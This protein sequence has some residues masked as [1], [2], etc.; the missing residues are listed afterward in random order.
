MLKKTNSGNTPVTDPRI[1]I[2]IDCLGG[3]NCPRAQVGGISLFFRKHPSS[4]IRFLLFGEKETLDGC[5]SKYRVPIGK[6]RI[7]HTAKKISAED[8]PSM[9]LRQGKESSMWLA[10]DAVKQKQAIAN[11]SAGNTGALMAIS[12]FLL[13]SLPDVDRPALIQIIPTANNGRAA[14]LD[15][16]ANIDCDA[17]NLY[18]FA[19]MGSVFYS[20]ITGRENPRIGLLNVGSEDLKGNDVVKQAAILIRN[21]ALKNNFYGFIEGSDL[22]R[23][24]VDVIVTDGFTGNIALKTMEGTAKFLVSNLKE[25]LGA[26]PLS[27]LFSLFMYGSLRSFKSKMNPEN[28]N[29]AMFIGLNGISVKSHGN[30]DEKSFYFSIENTLKLI[31]ANVNSRITNLMSVMTE[32]AT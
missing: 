21:S 9:A 22:F 30:A 15:M 17:E 13:R 24:V 20:A 4:Q 28:H 29:G 8:K 12:K 10:V 19:L 16:G 2:A 14:L 32:A 27:R 7:I 23:N 5:I 18:Q 31:G 6:Y 11:I 3:D 26:S 1:T 25:S